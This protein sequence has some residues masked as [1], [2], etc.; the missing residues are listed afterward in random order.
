M[1]SYTL[2]SLT[3]DLYQIVGRV[4]EMSHAVQMEIVSVLRRKLVSDEQLK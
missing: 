1:W 2:A 3:Q 4:E